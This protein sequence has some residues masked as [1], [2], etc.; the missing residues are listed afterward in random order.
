[1]LQGALSAAG[2]ETLLEAP[3]DV[4]PDSPQALGPCPPPL[5]S[6]GQVPRQP[7]V[8]GS[9]RPAPQSRGL[10]NGVCKALPLTRPSVLFQKC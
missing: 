7:K 4:Q 6:W 9:R 2:I 10:V 5:S 1:M 8:V 3:A